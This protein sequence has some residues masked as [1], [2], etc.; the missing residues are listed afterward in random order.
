MYKLYPAIP[1]HADMEAA[2]AYALGV[3]GYRQI[4]MAIFEAEALGLLS[5][6]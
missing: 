5:A 3:E 1:F 6:N 4:W 2:V